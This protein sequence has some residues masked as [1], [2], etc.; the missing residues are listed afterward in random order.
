MQQTY[1]LFK[2]KYLQIFNNGEWAS[3]YIKSRKHNLIF[4]TVFTVYIETFE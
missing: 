2:V 4:K 1:S 3:S